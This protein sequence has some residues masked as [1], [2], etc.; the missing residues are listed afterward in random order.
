[1]INLYEEFIQREEKGNPYDDESEMH[2]R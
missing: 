2:V 1:M